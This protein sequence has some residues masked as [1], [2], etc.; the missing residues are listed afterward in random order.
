MTQAP[1]DRP[2]RGGEE[3]GIITVIVVMT[4]LH[5]IPLR[6]IDTVIAYSVALFPRR[7]VRKQHICLL[8]SVT[9]SLT[10]S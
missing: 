3:D 4:V 8:L 6:R 1:Y 10:E 5:S 2:I 7:L 9:L